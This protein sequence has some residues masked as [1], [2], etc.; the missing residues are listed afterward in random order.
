LGQPPPEQTQLPPAHPTKAHIALPSHCSLHP[1]PAHDMRQAEPDPH[2]RT[3]L[4]PPQFT[5]H[6]PPF[7]HDVLQLPVEQSTLHLLAPQ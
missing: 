5:V 4:P 6:A 1:P 2:A 7:G 3:Q